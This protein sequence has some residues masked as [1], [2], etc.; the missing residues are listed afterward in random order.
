MINAYYTNAPAMA[1]EAPTAVAALTLTSITER[2]GRAIFDG[3]LT[4]WS[5]Y[6]VRLT[7]GLLEVWPQDGQSIVPLRL[8]RPKMPEKWQVF[9]LAMG[10]SEAYESLVAPRVSDALNSLVGGPSVSLP[11]LD[12][13]HKTAVVASLLN[14]VQD[15]C[16]RLA[17]GCED[18]LRESYISA[19]CAY[20]ACLQA[21]FQLQIEPPILD[22]WGRGTRYDGEKVPFEIPE[23]DYQSL[24][25]IFLGA[26]F[27]L[28]FEL[29]SDSKNDYAQLVYDIW[30]A[31]D[32]LCDAPTAIPS[33]LYPIRWMCMSRSE[34][35][36]PEGIR[37]IIMRAFE[38]FD[39]GWVATHGG[40]AKILELTPHAARGLAAVYGRALQW[41]YKPESDPAKL[42]ERLGERAAFIKRLAA[43]HA[44]LLD[45]VDGDGRLYFV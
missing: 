43:L 1:P 5:A 44:R 21:L 23:D 4:R 18:D 41:Y 25:A 11:Q 16:Y 7:S 19:A 2:R 24:H 10:P 31:E 28:S 37:K 26:A 35:E 20:A 6:E 12:R 33:H 39:C 8:K 30:R 38:P 22:D 14:S 17:F 13:D 27:E 32:A 3:P 40:P 36:E 15:Y 45:I 34:T 9:Q 29:Y 42:D